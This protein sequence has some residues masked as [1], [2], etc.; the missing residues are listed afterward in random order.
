MKTAKREITYSAKQYRRSGF[1][2]SPYFVD[3]QENGHLAGSLILDKPLSDDELRVLLNVF[4]SR[5]QGGADLSFSDTTERSLN[6][7][8]NTDK[9]RLCALESTIAR[10]MGRDKFEKNYEEKCYYLAWPIDGAGQYAHETFWISEQFSPL[11]C[12]KMAYLMGEGQ[13]KNYKILLSDEESEVDSE[14]LA[15]AISEI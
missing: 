11:S 15:F 5:S 3:L 7:L 12:L 13:F 6:E 10:K 1:G 2:C 4:T 9:Y 8:F 14:L